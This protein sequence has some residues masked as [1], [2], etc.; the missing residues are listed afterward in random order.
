M[1]I[2]AIALL[3]LLGGPALADPRIGDPAPS[4]TL[5][6]L[7][8]KPLVLPAGKPMI[9][10]FF[11]TWCGPC[12]EAVAVLDAIYRMAGGKLALVIV[13]VK[14]DAERVNAF[15][16]EHPLPPGAVMALDPKGETAQRWGQ[17]R[18]PTTFILDGS[19]VIRHINRGFGSGYEE[20]MRTW[21]KP[22][23]KDG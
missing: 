17:H 13:D 19:G 1:R 2:T 11:A 8:G 7:A 10:D 3:T 16:A 23:T 18:F 14:E 9:V 12:H 21:L 5:T 6:D 15:L 22:F 20:R 4:A